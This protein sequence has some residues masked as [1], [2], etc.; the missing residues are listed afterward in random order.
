MAS[1]IPVGFQQ[2]DPTAF[3]K[4]FITSRLEETCWIF[5]GFCHG[6]RKKAH[7]VQH[8]NH[9]IWPCSSHLCL[10]IIFLTFLTHQKP[11]KSQGAFPSP[12]AS[13]QKIG[14][15]FFFFQSKKRR[16]WNITS[17]TLPRL[18]PAVPLCRYPWSQRWWSLQR[19][20]RT[21]DPVRGEGGVGCGPGHV[22]L[23]LKKG[24]EGN[25][26]S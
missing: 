26:I 22:V 16:I 11:K 4:T 10:T 6:T 24:W 15:V 13:P 9:N 1:W 14:P 19:C 25:V 8:L 3:W 17:P 20:G 18:H 21:W 12:P 2:V 7:D 5:H 23:F